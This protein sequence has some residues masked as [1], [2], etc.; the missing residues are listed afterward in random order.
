MLTIFP[1]TV[2]PITRRMATATEG[3]APKLLHQFSKLLKSTTT[4]PSSSKPAKVPARHLLEYRSEH[5][6]YPTLKLLGTPHLERLNG[7][8]ALN[9]L[10][11]RNFK[12]LTKAAPKSETAA[13]K[14]DSSRPSQSTQMIAPYSVAPRLA[15]EKLGKL[16][17]TKTHEDAYSIKFSNG[18][19]QIGMGADRYYHP[20]LSIGF[21]DSHGYCRC[22]TT[23]MER[24]APG[25]LFEN[26]M[27]ME[28]LV[29]EHYWGG[30]KFFSNYVEDY[31]ELQVQ[32]L[33]EF[34]EKYD[35]E[36]AAL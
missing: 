35:K 18:K 4:S 12:I 17:F 13:E 2:A 1:R 20:Y 23:V 6:S 8:S 9:L 32:H 14:A 7:T 34:V 29:E 3:A 26:D 11:R 27:A 19:Y 15:A 36:I 10:I 22:L 25:K 30:P 16:G 33:I 28:K 5:R 31:A 24:L 21:K